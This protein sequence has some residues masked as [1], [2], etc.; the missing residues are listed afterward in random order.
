MTPRFF[1]FAFVCT[2]AGGCSF[3]EARE[4]RAVLDAINTLRD[5]SP[6]DLT[7]RNA[8]IETL[9][10]LPASSVRGRQARDA[11]VEAYRLIAEGK[12]G[13]AKVKAELDKTGVPPKNAIDDLEAASEKLK[14]SEPALKACQKAAVELSLARR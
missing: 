8:L 11:C 5:S 6:D 14:Q 13:A 1:C 4:D 10:K 3:S 2:V 9:G 7:N 12:A